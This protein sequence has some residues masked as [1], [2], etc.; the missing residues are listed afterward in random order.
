MWVL[1]R[2]ESGSDFLLLKKTIKMNWFDFGLI[3][4][5]SIQNHNPVL[6]L[7]FSIFGIIPSQFLSITHLKSSYTIFTR[8]LY[9]LTLNVPHVTPQT[10][11]FWLF[12]KTVSLN[13][14]FSFVFSRSKNHT[15]VWSQQQH[16][17]WFKSSCVNNLSG[18]NPYRPRLVRYYPYSLPVS[19][20]IYFVQ[21]FSWSFA[22]TF[23][24]AL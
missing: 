14:I 9:V 17:V 6:R 2:N 21:F 18:L 20:C 4:E 1:I 5:F 15:C 24:R 10:Q 8:W 22:P 3:F 12:S 16:D 23:F 13:L 19:H 11:F 7:Y